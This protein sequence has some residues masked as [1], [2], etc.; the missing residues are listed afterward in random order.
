MSGAVCVVPHNV[1][2]LINGIGG[3]FRQTATIPGTILHVLPSI[4]LSFAGQFFYRGGILLG[5]LHFA[6]IC[7]NK[8]IQRAVAVFTSLFY[9]AEKNR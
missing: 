6:C 2:D 5:V 7:M 3:L 9:C 4:S 1:M 8:R